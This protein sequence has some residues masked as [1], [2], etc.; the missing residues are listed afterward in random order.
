V[1][2]ATLL[3]LLLVL[4]ATPASAAAV[5]LCSRILSI[6]LWVALGLTLASRYAV[7]SWNEVEE[8]NAL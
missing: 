8:S 4:G 6:W 2:E 1:A 7:I 3:G 5:A